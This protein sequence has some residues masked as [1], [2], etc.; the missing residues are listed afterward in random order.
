VKSYKVFRKVG[1]SSISILAYDHILNMDGDY[2]A[3]AL[4]NALQKKTGDTCYVV[5][6]Q[7]SR[8][9]PHRNRR[10]PLGN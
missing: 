4:A 8:H 9:H 1:R 2:G 5:E 3:Q 10:N 7:T 6:Y